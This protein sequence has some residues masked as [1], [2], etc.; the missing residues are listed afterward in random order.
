MKKRKNAGKRKR[1]RISMK[2]INN[3][4]CKMISVIIPIYKVEKYLDKCVK[5]VINQTYSNLEIILVKKSYK[6]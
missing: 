1:N 4:E 3:H 6:S 2:T 5:S